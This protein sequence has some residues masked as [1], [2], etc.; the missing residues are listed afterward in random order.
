MA[1]ARR[2]RGPALAIA[3][4]VVIAIVAVVWWSRSPHRPA[5][6]STAHAPAVTTP[7]TVA[8][9]RVDPANEGRLVTVNGMLHADKPVRDAQLGVSADAL[10]L[11]RSV[12][13]RQWQEKCVAAKCDYTLVWAMQPIDSRRFKTVAGHQNPLRL[14][15]STARFPADDVRLGAFKIDA[16]LAARA[17]RPIAYP[18]GSAQLPPN[19]AATFRE[20]AGVLYTGADPEHAAAGDL[21]VSYRIIPSGMA[22]VTGMQSGDRLKMPPSH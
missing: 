6:V 5:P 15:F 13:M 16:A 21:R 9:D 14:P 3:L 19:L 20:N 1:R 10:V 18:V 7:G 2:G 4:L 12:M 17:T 22:R 11:L 8:A